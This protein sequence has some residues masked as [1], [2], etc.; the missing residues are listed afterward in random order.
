MADEDDGQSVRRLVWPP[1]AE[2]WSN[3]KA[4]SLVA[5]LLCSLRHTQAMHTWLRCLS[6]T[7]TPM[8]AM[9]HTAG[10]QR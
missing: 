9:P 4:G 7:P 3:I 5:G 2:E 8:Y 10:P 1:G 6:M